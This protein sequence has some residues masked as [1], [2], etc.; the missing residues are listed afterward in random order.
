M[1][2]IAQDAQG[3]ERNGSTGGGVRDTSSTLAA[4]TAAGARSRSITR[5]G[6]IGRSRQTRT[7]TRQYPS[8]SLGAADRISQPPAAAVAIT[9]AI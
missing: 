5:G 2:P 7:T 8:R 3:R 4:E 1:S 9:I 6:A